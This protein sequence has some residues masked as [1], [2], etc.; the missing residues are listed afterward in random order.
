MVTLE[1]A[2]KILSAAEKKATELRQPMNIAVADGGGNL[3][4]HIA[5]G[6]R[7]ARQYRYLYQEGVHLTGL[8]HQHEGPRDPVAIRRAVLRHPCVERRARHDFR[9]RR[10]VATRQARWWVQSA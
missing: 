1:D 10:A 7:V 4:A 6:R 5:H 3:V 8:R 2:R 9:G